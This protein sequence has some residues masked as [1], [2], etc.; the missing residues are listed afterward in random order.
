MAISKGLKGWRIKPLPF[1]KNLDG[2]KNYTFEV[3]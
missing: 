1:I 2:L 3:W